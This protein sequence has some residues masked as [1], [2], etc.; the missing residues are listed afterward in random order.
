[1]N[2]SD[3][4]VKLCLIAIKF[5]LFMFIIH[6]MHLHKHLRLKCRHLKL[7][8]ST[9][10]HKKFIL[11]FWEPDVDTPRTCVDTLA[12]RVYIE[13]LSLRCRHHKVMCWHMSWVYKYQQ[14]HIRHFMRKLSI[15]IFLSLSLPFSLN[16]L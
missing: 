6:F 8:V 11:N 16:S 1:M 13:M 10:Y 12:H 3:L 15:Y 7:Y 2:F 5:V 14:T 9:H 4:N